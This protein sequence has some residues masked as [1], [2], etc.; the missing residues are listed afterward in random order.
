MRTIIIG[1]AL[2]SLVASAPSWADVVELN[3]GQR[4]EGIFKKAGPS[5]VVIEVGGQTITFDQEKV[6]AIYFGSAQASQIRPSTL[7]EAIKAVKA[8]QSVVAGSVSYRDYAP[9]VSDAK[10][11]VDRYLQEPEQR[12]YAVRSAI[13]EAMHYY[14]LASSAWNTRVARS[15]YEAV[16]EVGKDPA[17]SKC[18]QAQ[19]A[20][21]EALKI[22]PPT[23]GTALPDSY[24]V[25]SRLADAGLPGLW[26]CASEKIAVAEQA[27]KDLPPKDKP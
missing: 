2:L 23:R 7:N 12:D 26:F 19:A 13:S 3:T 4:I 17:I 1:L 5:G 16:A 20:V 9:R 27:L 6:R 8:L 11:V 14:V 10:I 25:G 21:E 15:G 22:S 24:W 18:R